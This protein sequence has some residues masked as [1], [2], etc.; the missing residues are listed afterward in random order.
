M[1]PVNKGKRYPSDPLTREECERL[2]NTCRETWTGTRDR[3][4]LALLWRC[5]LR[6][7]ES[8]ALEL[9]DFRPG[10]PCTVR[11][12]SPK[13]AAR[14][15]AP[16]EIGLDERT[17]NTVRAWIDVRGEAPGPLFC[18]RPGGRVQTPYL[19][20]MLPRLAKTAGIARRVHPHALRHTFARELYD[21]ATGIVHIQKALGH[22]SLQ[23]TATY[24]ESIGASDVVS[25]TAGREW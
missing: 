6:A 19:R 3:A 7:A 5:G 14:G 12:R 9:S 16:R 8:C 18:T 13:G 21:E 23:T 17:C 24:L 10:S 25:M 2:L 15:K 22:D 4:Q 1:A 20:R 11:V